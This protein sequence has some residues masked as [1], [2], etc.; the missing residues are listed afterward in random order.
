MIPTLLCCLATATAQFNFRGQNPRLFTTAGAS[1]SAY[2]PS[3][4]NGNGLINGFNSNGFNS[5]VTGVLGQLGASYTSNGFLSTNSL[6]MTAIS[7]QT[8]GMS[9]TMPTAAFPMA[10]A[11]FPATSSSFGTLGTATLGSATLGTAALGLGSLGGLGQ[12]LTETFD[13]EQVEE[14]YAAWEQYK[15]R[16]DTQ[17]GVPESA[18][19][20]SARAITSVD[21]WYAAFVVSP[22][23]RATGSSGPVVTANQPRRNTFPTVNNP[24]RPI[25]PCPP[26]TPRV[27]C[28]RNA[29]EIGNRF[30][31]YDPI[32]VADYEDQYYQRLARLGYPG[33]GPVYPTAPLQGFPNYQVGPA[34]TPFAPPQTLDCEIAISYDIPF[35]VPNVNIGENFLYYSQ[36]LECACDATKSPI[37]SQCRVKRRDPESDSTTL[38]PSLLPYPLMFYDEEYL[39][40]GPNEQQVEDYNP[41]PDFDEFDPLDPVQQECKTIVIPG[42]TPPP[43]VRFAGM[44]QQQP[45]YGSDYG[46]ESPYACFITYTIAWAIESPF[47]WENSYETAV[48]FDRVNDMECVC[49][50]L[51]NPILS[52][53]R[54]FTPNEFPIP[55]SFVPPPAPVVPVVPA[56]TRSRRRSFDDDTTGKV[57]TSEETSAAV[58]DTTDTDTTSKVASPAINPVKR[59]LMAA[60]EAQEAAALAQEATAALMKAVESARALSEQAQKSA[61]EATKYARMASLHRRSRKSSRKNK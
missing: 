53:C 20:V 61:D 47:A 46:R 48:E 18:L 58:D 1:R 8:Q 10:N 23:A 40:N 55:V 12:S 5:P 9:T 42:F 52:T 2:G 22:L 50:G 45:Q 25:V 44:Q 17:N 59:A 41:C 57:A 7:Q 13:P 39:A 43:R 60:K 11:V 54:A 28:E 19:A 24:S 29:Q 51:S 33:R 36:D 56:V 34:P 37:M 30:P 4:G 16:F 49:D 35:N 15:T 3:F 21:K 27:V 14:P 32:D 26:G 31:E 6:P 38:P